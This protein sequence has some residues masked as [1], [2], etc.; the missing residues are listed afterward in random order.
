MANQKHLINPKGVEKTYQV[1]N[2]VE[3][4]VLAS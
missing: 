1:T 4:G 2:D 3:T